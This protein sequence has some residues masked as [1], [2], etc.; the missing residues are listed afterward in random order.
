MQKIMPNQKFIVCPSCQKEILVVP[1]LK[2]MA[3]A[4]Q[5]HSQHHIDFTRLQKAKLRNTLTQSLLL[6]VAEDRQPHSVWLLV[7]SYFGCK[8][9]RGVALTEAHADEWVQ[10]QYGS[11]PSGSYF[12][13]KSEVLKG[14]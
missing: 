5:Q 9:V 8:Q 10:T 7:E 3:N 4:I 1:D 12:R 13:E 11:N 14:E 6:I 2:E